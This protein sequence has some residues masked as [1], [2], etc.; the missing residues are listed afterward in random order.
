MGV[1]VENPAEVELRSVQ[2][3]LELSSVQL[4]AGER[5]REQRRSSWPWLALAV[6]AA[7][8]GVAIVLAELASLGSRSA[9]S[10]LW[11]VV[12]AL[13][14][15][16]IL[17][18]KSLYRSPLQLRVID[19]TLAIV[20]G[21]A[22]ASAATISLRVVVGDWVGV[23]EES[24]RAWIFATLLLT[25]GRVALTDYERRGRRAGK[26][27]SPTLIVGAGRVGRLVARRLDEHPEIGL[28]PVGFLDKEPLHTA[29]GPD[30]PV[31]GA[32]WDLEE[33]IAERQ[34]EHVAVAFSTAPD[35]VLL[36]VVKRCEKIGVRT[37]VVPRFFEKS[38]EHA[39]VVS[40]GGLPL[41]ASH[42][43][44]PTSWEFR[45]KHAL[46]RILAA[47][48]VVLIAPLLAAVSVGVWISLGRPILYRA[49]RVGRDGWRFDMLKFRSMHPMTEEERR[50]LVIDS[51]TGTGGNNGIDR[52]T[53][54]GTFIRR[55]SLDEL[56]QLFNVLNGD[57]SLVGPR[58]ERTEYVRAYERT[59]PRYI[60]RQRVK[61]GVTGWAQVSGLRGKTSL[62]DRAEWDNYYIENWSFWLDLKILL[63]T[64]VAVFQ[65]GEAD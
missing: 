12:F 22:V 35:D 58:P 28:R 37:S 1:T 15:L 53:R 39:T 26:F 59:I 30:L 57:M 8:L 32:S 16:V 33:V 38:T 20:T 25:A 4:A 41:V 29:Q 65:T 34:I 43:P 49:E 52:R 46:D 23:T 61:S 50:N 27:G 51:E 62:A 2:A 24:V 63:L 10:S 42:V 3:E 18:R 56:P 17:Y 5:W 47:L 9:M 6:D 48:V 7:M 45:L 13:A 36:D 21:T 55:T 44:H 40:L 64:F 54:F 31:L 60:E 19:T 11:A 14:T